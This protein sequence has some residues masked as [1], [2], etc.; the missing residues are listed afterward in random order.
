MPVF[1]SALSEID[2]S[3]NEITNWAFIDRLEDVF[4][5]LSAIRV[6][7]NPLYQSLHAADGKAL[8]AEDGYMLTLARIGRLKNLNYSPVCRMSMIYRGIGPRYRC[9]ERG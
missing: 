3:Y 9:E 2:L 6:A 1:S 7:H 8:S 5:G 4:P